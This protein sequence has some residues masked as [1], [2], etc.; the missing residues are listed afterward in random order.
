MHEWG[1]ARRLLQLIEDEAR[2]RR[3]TRVGRVRLC[4]ALNPAEC[5]TLR[6]NF[7]A[8]AR[9]TVAEQAELEIESRPVQGRCPACGCEVPMSDHHQ[10]CPRCRMQILAP[11]DGNLLRIVELAAV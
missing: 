2:A 7:L 9:G 3:L 10:P 5:E 4:G 8:A 11:V 6:F 1:L